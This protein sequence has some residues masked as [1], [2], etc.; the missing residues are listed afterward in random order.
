MK[1]ALRIV[2]K[3]SIGVNVNTVQHLIPLQK[4]AVHTLSLAHFNEELLRWRGLLKLTVAELELGFTRIR[5]HL[6]SLLS[7]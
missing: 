5:C 7:V 4:G 2:L 3:T 6:V 1:Y